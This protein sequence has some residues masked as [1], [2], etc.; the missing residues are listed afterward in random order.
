MKRAGIVAIALLLTARMAP[1]QYVAP[2]N[3]TLAN[4]YVNLL[5]STNGNFNPAVTYMGIVQPQLQMQA[6][7]QQLQNG[8][9]LG[10]VMPGG[11]AP[12]RNAGIADT[13]YFRARF[14]QYQQYFNTLSNRSS[15]GY[16]TQT[17]VG[18]A[19]MSGR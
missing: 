3:G 1:A 4:P 17:G 12:P 16:P 10:R 14:L 13:G 19:A 15:V 8:M 5:G 9:N 18:A 2:Y 6:G 7:M 11:V